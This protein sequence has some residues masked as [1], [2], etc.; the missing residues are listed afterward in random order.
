SDS[1]WPHTE[2]FVRDMAVD[3]DDETLYKIVRGNAI[4]MLHLDLD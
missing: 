2:Q 3:L 1:T 4:K